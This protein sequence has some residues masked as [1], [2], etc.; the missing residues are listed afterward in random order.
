MQRPTPKHQEV[1]KKSC[2]RV[3]DRIKQAREVKD[4]TRSPTESTNL[5][6]EGLRDL[7]INPLV[8]HS[9]AGHRAPYTFE[10]DV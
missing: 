7:T 9:R 6:P 1:L 2:E 10:A 3:G 4:T 5:G 8:Q